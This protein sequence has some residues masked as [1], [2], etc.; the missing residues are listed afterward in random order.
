[1][2]RGSKKIV[3]FTGA[4]ISTPSGI[5]DF[6]S[7]GSG[8]WENI[9][10]FE[11]ISLSAFYRDPTLFYNWLHPLAQ[12]LKNA[13]PNPAHIAIV[14]MEEMGLVHAVLTQNID[15]LHQKAGSKNVLELHGTL[16]EMVCLECGR[17]QASES[18]MDPFVSRR[19]IPKCPACGAVLK[20]DIVFF[21]EML[22]VDTWKQSEQFC[23]TADLMMVMGSSLEV[24]PANQLPL[25]AVR[26]GARL[27]I[28]NRTPTPQ[29]GLA[30]CVI[31]ANIE[32]VLPLLIKTLNGEND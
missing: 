23:S 5:P 25:T 1:L 2:I 29:D 10:P 4:G 9:D 14:R 32:D 8:L 31:S 16:D 13:M 28:L 24:V 26:H 6:R 17:R 21:E 19:Q 3:V 20:P 30:D 7:A 11:V 22:P 12:R 18:F 27:A 15:G